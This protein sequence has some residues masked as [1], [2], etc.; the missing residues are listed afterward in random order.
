MSDTNQLIGSEP[1]SRLKRDV[2]LAFGIVLF[3]VLLLAA[4]LIFRSEGGSAVVTV[5]GKEY[6]RVSLSTDSETP[7]ETDLGYNLLIVEDGEAYIK[8]A[9][10]PDKICV[11]HRR[12]KYSGET[13]TCLPNEVVVR[14][15]KKDG[16]GVDAVS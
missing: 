13:V 5:S 7:I 4:M 3:S 9:S 8:D 2:M 14:I 15:V 10:C 6:V 11:H 1:K 12:I 16:G